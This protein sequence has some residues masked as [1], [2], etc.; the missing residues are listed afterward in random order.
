MMP[1]KLIRQYQAGYGRRPESPRE[2]AA[3]LATAVN[4]LRRDG[5][6]YDAKTL[7]GPNDAEGS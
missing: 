3:A 6:R 2:I 5:I 4:L 7:V 1:T